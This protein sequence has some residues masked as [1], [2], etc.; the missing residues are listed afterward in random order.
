M[1]DF[2]EFVTKRNIVVLV[3]QDSYKMF[4]AVV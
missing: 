4:N 3:H 1:M 2:P